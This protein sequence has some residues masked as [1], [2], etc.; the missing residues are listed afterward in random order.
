[1]ALTTLANVRSV[2]GLNSAKYTDAYLNMLISDADA[3]IKSYCK[4]NLELAPYTEYYDGNEHPN[5][6]LR[7]ALVLIG[8]TTITGGSLSGTISV[9]STVG[10]QTTPDIDPLNLPTISVQTGTAPYSQ[11]TVT[12][13]AT[14]GSTFTGCSGGT[15]SIQAGYAV[16]TPTVF[17]DQQGGYGQPPNAFAAGTQQVQGS[18]W[19]MNRD[20]GRKSKR[21]LLQRW[22][23]LGL[24]QGGLPWAG[25]PY[26][27]G[28]KLAAR[29]LP[30]WPGGQGNIKVQYSAGYSAAELPA[31]LTYAATM[32]VAYMVRVLPTGAPLQ[33][34][35]L[36]S[37]NYSIATLSGGIGTVPELGTI[38][39]TLSR[40]RDV[41]W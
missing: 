11:T 38:A 28:G 36:G 30:C 29:R 32:L 26:I 23:G 15:G 5:I 14:T 9:A 1:M 37:Y 4:Q 34:E 39:R 3:A 33:S 16:G 13:T 10:F 22:N 2:P 41:S 27:G 21:G 8:Q 18:G 35:G 17:F 12:Y 25:V 24:G 6:A 31:D 20:Q 40:Y 7:Q 19:V